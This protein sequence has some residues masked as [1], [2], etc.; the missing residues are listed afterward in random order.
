MPHYSERNSDKNAS[1]D[2]FTNVSS[3]IELIKQHCNQIYIKYACSQGKIKRKRR[4]FNF[5]TFYS[6]RSIEYSNVMLCMYALTQQ[7]ATP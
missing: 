1:I 4:T 5:T 2:M 7:V 3:A 6:T